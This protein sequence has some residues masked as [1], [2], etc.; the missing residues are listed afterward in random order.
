MMPS[1][2]LGSISEPRDNSVFLRVQEAVNYS[3]VARVPDLGDPISK[4][5]EGATPIE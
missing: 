3:S 4:L 5:L 2:Y 1:T